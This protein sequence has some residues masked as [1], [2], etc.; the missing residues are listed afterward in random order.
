MTLAALIAV[1]A[2]PLLPSCSSEHPGTR[3]AF[4]G[5]LADAPLFSGPDGSSD[6]LPDAAAEEDAT[7]S[8]SVADDMLPSD[9]GSMTRDGGADD[10][11]LA[12]GNAGA[13]A[14]ARGGAPDVDGSS[15]ASADA[16]SALETGD[17]STDADIPS[18]APA[19]AADARAVIPVLSGGAYIF[20]AG[21]LSFAVDPQHGG[22][23]VAFTLAGE[24]VLTGPDANATNYGSTFWT[25]PQ[26]DWGWPPPPEIDNLPYMASI[27]SGTLVLSG[28]DS[29]ALGVRVTKAFSLDGVSG[30]VS[31]DYTIQNSGAVSRSLAPWEI[32]RVHPGGIVFFPSGARAYSADSGPA[33]PTVQA[34]GTTWFEQ[35]DA[36]AATP[37]GNT[38]YFADGTRGW[39]ARASAGTLFVKK[40][41]EVPADAHA[42]G[43]SAI[44]LYVSGDR[45]YIELENQG[46]YAPLAP[47]ASI[48]WTVHWYLVK[49]PAGLD[50]SVGT[51]ELVSFVDGLR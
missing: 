10:A 49:V 27:D 51:A 21:D 11:G 7:A 25:S 4:D 48:H 34:A 13:D 28:S 44:E 17:G 30:A 23:V 20:A 38:K 46:A 12:D 40:F 19:V 35:L 3:E 41:P 47:G 37:S 2:V 39:L 42:P 24:N 26:S 29:R 33:L 31:L 9:A 14:D 43:E 8:D 22:R 32:T 15:D 45:A 50:A 1:V 36:D 6:A 18:D 16:P 5:T